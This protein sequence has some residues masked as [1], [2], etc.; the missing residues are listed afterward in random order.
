MRSRLTALTSAIAAVLIFAVAVTAATTD[1][2][3]PV[4]A[5][6]QGAVRGIV[7]AGVS[8]FL[9]LPYAAPP[10]GE[11][12]WQPPKPHPSWSGS[13]DASRAGS[14]CAQMRFR[15]RGME[16]SEDCLY[17]NIYRPE[18]AGR[19]LPVMV[20]IHGGTFIGGAGVWYP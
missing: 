1:S 2:D 20:W 13:L 5:T 19:G 12:R 10:V 9:G 7:R 11:L 3:G 18:G 15:H 14:A 8:E 6:R 17:L 16:G 4:V